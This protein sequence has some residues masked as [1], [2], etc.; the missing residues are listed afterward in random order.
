MKYIALA[1]VIVYNGPSI[2]KLCWT[3]FPRCDQIL[4]QVSQTTKP[5]GEWVRGVTYIYDLCV[6]LGLGGCFLAMSCR[7]GDFNWIF[8]AI[9]LETI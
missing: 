6:Y 7:L 4:G 9:F 3:I 1:Y 2:L 8:N 5:R